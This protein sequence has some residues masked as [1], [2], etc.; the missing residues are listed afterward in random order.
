MLNT[1]Q[2]NKISSFTNAYPDLY[3]KI[4]TSTVDD[5]PEA[6]IYKMSQ[7]IMM[8]SNV[9]NQ[10]TGCK[11]YFN[12]ELAI[13]EL[14]EEN[15]LVIIQEIG[16]YCLYDSMEK[17]NIFVDEK[18]GQTTLTQYQIILKERR[19]IIF[20][21]K[22]SDDEFKDICEKIFGVKILVLKMED[23]VKFM[24]ISNSPAKAFMNSIDV[25]KV[26][27]GIYQNKDDNYITGVIVNSSPKHFTKEKRLNIAKKWIK[28]NLPNDIRSIIYYCIYKFMND[29]A[30]TILTF[31]DIMYDLGY[32]IHEFANMRFWVK[33]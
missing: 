19:K 10:I 6:T 3:Q 9:Y 22:N 17:Y 1:R 5:I 20:F 8:T 31:M 29:D 18:Y 24:I 4:I 13:D 28:N 33:K 16:L 14:N 2:I 12:I 26:Y 15:I 25:L 27:L 21:A 32:K 7:N 11:V 30:L 23:H